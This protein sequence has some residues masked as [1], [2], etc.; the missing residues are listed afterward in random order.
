MKDDNQ[1]KKDDVAH[2][3]RDL[4]MK[5]G[6]A[7]GAA[8]VT[9]VR[10]KVASANVTV[11]QVQAASVDD[12]R[13]ALLEANHK[14][15]G[16]AITDLRLSADS[17]GKLTPA[18]RKLT[19]ADLIALAQKELGHNVTLSANAKALV[20]DDIKSIQMA[21]YRDATSAATAGGGDAKIRDA[22]HNACC[23]CCPCCCAATVVEPRRSAVL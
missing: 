9:I 10:S 18:A 21:F 19:K 23:C 4:L 14:P 7:A 13:A 17:V 22:I 16:T 1:S 3:R 20:A 2:E 12:L 6:L 5:L 8:A 15:P 11:S